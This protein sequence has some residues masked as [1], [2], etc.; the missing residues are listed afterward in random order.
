MPGSFNW[1][2]S[3]DVW[4]KIY[5]GQGVNCR[6]SWF[7]PRSFFSSRKKSELAHLVLESAGKYAHK[8]THKSTNIHRHTYKLIHFKVSL[9]LRAWS[10]I[11]L[12]DSRRSGSM[13]S[14]TTTNTITIDQDAKSRIPLCPNSSYFKKPGKL[15]YFRYLQN[16]NFLCFSG[17][18]LCFLFS[19]KN[20]LI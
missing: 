11:S 6:G 4:L 12:R 2:A 9:S 1:Q 19:K 14:E 3:A 16:S 13:P 8:L 5:E 10:V 7:H 20:L 15:A 18:C 17:F